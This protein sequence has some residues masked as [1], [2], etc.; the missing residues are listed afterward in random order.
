MLVAAIGNEVVGYGSLVLQSSYSPFASL[1]NRLTL[2]YDF[3]NQ[4]TRSILPFNF[5]FFTQGQ[6]WNDTWQNR[7]PSA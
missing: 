2:G 5:I 7:C 6:V 1:T 3:S 4:E